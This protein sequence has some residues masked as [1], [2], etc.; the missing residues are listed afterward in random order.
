MAGTGGDGVLISARSQDRGKRRDGGKERQAELITVLL[1][2][3]SNTTNGYF[4]Y[5]G[6]IL[7]DSSGNTS[8]YCD[9]NNVIFY[10]TIKNDL[11]PLIK[12][13]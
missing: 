13:F 5:F 12:M 4:H 1:I 3:P 10:T 2:T 8:V 7:Y 6:F 9:K 11:V